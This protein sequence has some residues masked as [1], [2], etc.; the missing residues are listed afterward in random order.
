MSFTQQRGCGFRFIKIPFDTVD[1]NQRTLGS[2]PQAVNI[3]QAL[4]QGDQLFVFTWLWI[5]L[6]DLIDRKLQAINFL[7]EFTARFCTP[8]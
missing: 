7:G 8:L 2:F 5:Q 6:G 1:S 4:D 3:L